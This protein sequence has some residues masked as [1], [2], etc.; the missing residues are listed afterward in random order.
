MSRSVSNNLP[1]RF[2]AQGASDSFRVSP[3]TAGLGRKPQA[4]LP[5]A[6]VGFIYSIPLQIRRIERP[7]RVFEPHG[8]SDYSIGISKRA[9]MPGV[10]ASRE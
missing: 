8:P 4:P 10:A 5:W 3:G 7:D 6:L 9:I 1:A 2:C